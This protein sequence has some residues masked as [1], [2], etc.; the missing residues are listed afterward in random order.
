MRAR[1]GK[2]TIS[3]A[4]VMCIAAGSVISVLAGAALASSG[5]ATPSTV[6]HG[7]KV[8]VTW[9]GMLT[10]SLIFIDQCNNKAVVSPVTFQYGSDCDRLGEQSVSNAFNNG[11]GQTGTDQGAGLNP[12]FSTFVGLESSGQLGW[13]C[14]P[15][16]TPTGADDG[17][18]A[19][20]LIYNP[21]VI[22]VTDYAPATPTDTIL[23]TLSFAAPSGTPPVFTADSPPSALV[24]GQPFT[25]TFAATGTPTP[26]FNFRLYGIHGLTLDTTSGVWSGTV[27]QPG[28]YTYQVQADNTAAGTLGATHQLTVTRPTYSQV[29]VADGAVDYWR[30]NDTTSTAHDSA[31]ASDGTYS[32]SFPGRPRLYPGATSNDV[33]NKGG[34]FYLNDALSVAGSPG[35]RIAGDSTVEAWFQIPTNLSPEST[36]YMFKSTVSGPGGWGT[37]DWYGEVGSATLEYVGRGAMTITFPYNATSSSVWHHFAL[38]ISGSTATIYIDG[39]VAASSPA[40]ASTQPSGPTFIGTDGY[41]D[42]GGLD[43]MLQ[44]V[45]VYNR[46]M[47]AAQIAAHIA[48]AT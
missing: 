33:S 3:L 4:I 34:Y 5:T 42:G 6:T 37:V 1:A 18:P 12:D 45:A 22:R 10:N 29:V 17:T 27:T 24:A 47:T 28:T 43:G 26:T 8:R 7:Q 2:G 39:R 16:G 36:N 11:A 35:S 20:N 41:N 14:G 23:I 30:L 44:D 19:H 46:A 32:L 15:T 25:Y 40:A 31:G 48:A 38:T 21:C 9:S 13:G